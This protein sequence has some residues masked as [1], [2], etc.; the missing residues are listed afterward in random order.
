MDKLEPT[1]LVIPNFEL[2]SEGLPVEIEYLQE[3]IVG[4][5][6]DCHSSDK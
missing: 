2:I 6:M 1:V 3:D 5:V 4:K